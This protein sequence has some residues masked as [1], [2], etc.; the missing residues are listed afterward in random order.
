MRSEN[1]N[2]RIPAEVF[3]PGEYLKDELEARNWTQAEFAEILGKDTRLVYEVVN[4][5]RAITPETAIVLA[6]A[7]GTSPELWMNLESQYQLSKVRTKPSSVS[8][9]AELHAKFPVREMVKRGWIE[10]TKN[11]DVLEK[12]L[13]DFFGINNLNETPTFKHAA[14]KQTYQEENILQIAWLCRARKIASSAPADKFSLV[15]LEQAVDE[16]KR[17]L[18]F[19]DGTRK[20][21]SIL[22]KSGVRLVI[23]EQLPRTKI[24]GATF[25]LDGNSGRAPVIVLSL[26]TDRIDN[27]WHTLLHEI[28]HVRHKEGMDQPIIDVDILSD[29]EKPEFEIRANRSAANTLIPQEEMTGFIARVN[30]AFSDLQIVGFARRLHVH[31]GIVVGQLQFR[32]LIQWSHYRRHL[33]KVRRNIVDSAL[34]DGFGE[35]LNDLV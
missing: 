6:A 19:V 33:E 24:D 2:A 29:N 26:K 28:D 16:L 10:A 7:L 12:Q 18:E 31:P 20:A 17:E 27:F 5:K 30:P 15:K 25:W 21:A 9:K 34:S 13:F 3:P 22:A 32:G 1:M 14:K 11:V 23:V 35:T 4:G 8:Q